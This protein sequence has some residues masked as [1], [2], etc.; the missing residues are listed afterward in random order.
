[1]FVPEDFLVTQKSLEL[2]VAMT[3]MRFCAYFETLT[4]ERNVI[5][6]EK[7]RFSNKDTSVLKNMS[8]FT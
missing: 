8:R 6:I 3:K 1:M 7:N 5:G 2:S 4:G